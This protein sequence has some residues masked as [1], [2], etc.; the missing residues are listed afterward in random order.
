MI[1]III[2]SAIIIIIIIIIIY[3][4]LFSVYSAVSFMILLKILWNYT[5]KVEVC[6]ADWYSY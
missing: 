4:N 6:L 3:W 1:V 2:I 5:Q